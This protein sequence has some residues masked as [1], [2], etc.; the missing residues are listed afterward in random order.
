V[1]PTSDKV[2]QAVFNML[3][4]RGL[5]G[6]VVAA[7]LFCGTGALGIEAISRGAAHCVFMDRARDSLALCRKNLAGLGVGAD[8]FTLLQGDA[9]TLPGLPDLSAKIALAFLDPPYGKGLV[10]PALHNL[11]ASGSTENAFMAVIETAAGEPVSLPEGS[12]T[13][14]AKIYGETRIILATVS[15]LS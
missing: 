3:A 14:A 8:R 6:D 1:R 12:I 11:R 10:E 7:D 13:E 9:R 2:R 15:R 5:P 4:S